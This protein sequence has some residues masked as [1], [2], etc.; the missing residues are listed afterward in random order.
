MIKFILPFPPSVNQLFPTVGKRRIKSAKYGK[1][2]DA[3]N[4]ACNQQNIPPIGERCIAVY[5]LNHPD[6]R[7]R[8]AENYCKAISDL[9]VDRGILL[10]DD[11]RYL[12]GTFPCWNDIK[13]SQV[14]VSLYSCEEFFANFVLGQQAPFDLS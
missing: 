2:I 12:Q 11:R 14:E 10:G 7:I 4:K 5:S 1:W 6:N 9:L 8:D 3:A 13:G